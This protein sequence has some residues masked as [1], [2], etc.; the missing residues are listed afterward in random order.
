MTAVSDGKVVDFPNA[1]DR[2]RRLKAE[3]ERL[4]RQSPT[5]WLFW[6]DDSAMKHGIAPAKLKT[7]IEATIKATEKQARQGQADQRQREQRAE[8]QRAAAD[9]KEE[10]QQREQRRTQ[11][12]ADKEA[13]RKQREREKELAAILKLPRADH[14]PRLKALAEQL[15]EDL[16]YMREEFSKLITVEEKSSGDTGFV[17]PWPEPV[18]L[19][20]L[21]TETLA[22]VRRYAV[23]HDDAAA[24]AVVLWIA[25]AWVHEI[26]THSPILLLTSAEAD[27]GKTNI[28]GVLKFLTPRCYAA[29][30]LTGPNLYRFV[31]HLHPT[32]IIDDADRLFERK[33]D[34]VHI[35]NVGW[36]RGTLVPRQEHGVTRWFDP[37][38]PKV[39]AGVGVILPKT[40]M[41]RT[42]PIKLLPKLPSEK[43]DDFAHIDDDT[44]VTLRRKFARFAADN[45]AA[46]K[47]AAPAMS[48]F[49]NRAKMN[50]KLLLA[51]ADLAGGDWPK[52]ARQAAIKLTRERR[53]PSE[54]K[55][56]LE[57]FRDMFAAHGP[58]LTSTQVQRLLTADE[59]GEWADFRG[60]GPISKRQIAVL[61]DAY[62]IHPDVIH[63]HG[64]K[65]ERGYKSEWFETPFRHYLGETP[66]C[67]RTSVRKPRGK[68]RK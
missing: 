37:F 14:E 67:K 15:G 1:E 68:P 21:L 44:F 55:R 34:L 32:L 9:R 12:Q 46:L 6:L 65:A 27:C 47:D 62:D 63:P 61:L 64:R 3:V 19:N 38:C 26:A 7:M 53:E 31:D 50:W 59:D 13:E 11:Q 25:F 60:R 22:Q 23:I 16:G 24:V 28:C 39:V 58:M 48:G 49:N 8:R 45:A 54:G 56:L 52:A 4:A 35:V 51:L 41:T 36:T 18:D 17:E 29:A 66:T 33:P 42:I 43:V 40:T 2:A 5:E 10:R 30:E 57:A 20:V